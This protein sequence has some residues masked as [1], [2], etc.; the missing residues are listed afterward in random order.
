MYFDLKVTLRYVTGRYP[1][2]L[3]L[4]CFG[5]FVGYPIPYSMHFGATEENFAKKERK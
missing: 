1:H 2:R 5:S 4:D 3:K